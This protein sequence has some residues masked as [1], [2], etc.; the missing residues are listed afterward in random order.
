MLQNYKKILKKRVNALHRRNISIS[1][2]TK[3]LTRRFKNKIT[4]FSLIIPSYLIRMHPV[5]LCSINAILWAHFYNYYEILMHNL[6]K[7]IHLLRFSESQIANKMIVCLSSVFFKPCKLLSS[8]VF[9]YTAD[10]FLLT[11]SYNYITFSIYSM[12]NF[13]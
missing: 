3:A 1:L 8:F 13:E 11:L 4:L 6:F 10:I 12:S 2:C 5:F 7:C 9:V